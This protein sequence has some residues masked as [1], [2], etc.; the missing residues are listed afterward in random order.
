MPKMHK[1]P[2]EKKFTKRRS[3]E[4]GLALA[5]AA[6][7]ATWRLY[8]DVFKLW[9]ACQFRRCRRHRCCAGEPARC[10]IRALPSIAQEEQ[11]AATKE[12]IKGGPRRVPSATHLEWKV[13]REPLPALA[14]WRITSGDAR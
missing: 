5:D 13:R 3:V 2:G 9:R 12:V 10:L 4:A 14:A 11:L 7:I 6:H 8:S 1:P